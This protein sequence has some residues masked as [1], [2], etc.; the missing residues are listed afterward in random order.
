MAPRITKGSF[1]AADSPNFKA[2]EVL[3]KVRD[4]R[5]YYDV[6]GELPGGEEIE[7]DVLMTKNGPEICLL[8]TSPS[9]RD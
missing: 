6:E 2:T 1:I 3:K 8:Y 5:V 9:P 4:G 7:F